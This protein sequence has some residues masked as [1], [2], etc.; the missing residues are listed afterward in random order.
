MKERH[1]ERIDPFTYRIRANRPEFARVTSSII[2][3]LPVEELKM[4]ETDL[5]T[6]L[7]RSFSMESPS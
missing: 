2:K 7:E 6:V 5:A 4:E 1:L 3:N